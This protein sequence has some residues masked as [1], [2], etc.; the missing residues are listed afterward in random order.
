MDDTKVSQSFIDSRA[1]EKATEALSRIAQ[2]EKSCDRRY[3]EITEGQKAIFKKLDDLGISQFR[4]WLTVA[5]G[6]IVILVTIIG[7]LFGKVQ[8]W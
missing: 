1:L 2:H 8:G 4:Q 6:L 7:I 5:G 3:V